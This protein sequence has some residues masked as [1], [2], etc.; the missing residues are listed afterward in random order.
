MQV[1]ISF[2][3][4]YL[5]AVWKTE[6]VQSYLFKT[7]CVLYVLKYNIVRECILKPVVKHKV[8]NKQLRMKRYVLY[9]CKW[10]KK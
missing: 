10:L 1:L 5:A 8:I 4:F 6:R 3:Q 2:D 7:R 9:M